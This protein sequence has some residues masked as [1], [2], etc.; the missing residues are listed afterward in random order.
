MVRGLDDDEAG[1]LELVDRTKLA[2]ETRIIK[3][4]KDEL[5]E[6]R[7]AVARESEERLLQE[8]NSQ[9][10]LVPNKL[11]TS[12]AAKSDRQ[13]QRSKIIA[14]VKRKSVAEGSHDVKRIKP[15]MY[16]IKHHFVGLDKLSIFAKS[17][18]SL[19]QRFEHRETSG[20]T[21][22][23][24]ASITWNWVLCRFQ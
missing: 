12:S 9:I 1:F 20:Q 17:I 14:C 16:N 21:S 23:I 7:L 3:E 4:E 8:M 5:E 24:Q 13:S 19:T 6:Y 10:A 22:H 18:S 2:E 11:I 15:G